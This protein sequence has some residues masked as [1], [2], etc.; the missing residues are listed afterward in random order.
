MGYPHSS[1]V[2]KKNQLWLQDNF[3]QELYFSNCWLVFKRAETLKCLKAKGKNTAEEVEY[4]RGSFC[5][6]SCEIP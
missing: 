3:T 2:K 6:R 1:M 4:I 5:S